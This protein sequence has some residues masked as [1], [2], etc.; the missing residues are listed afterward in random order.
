MRE[1]SSTVRS[2]R[3]LPAARFAPS[4]AIALALASTFAP[5]IRAAESAASVPAS[6]DARV[7]RSVLA[8]IE[9][10]YVD[11]SRVDANRM[12]W[13]AATALD[14]EI[15]EVLLESLPGAPE[16]TL[17]VAGESRS[18]PASDVH[19]I[20]R[21]ADTLRDV[22][23]FIAAHGA[24]SDD[25]SAAEYAAVNGILDSLD[26]HSLL[27]TPAQARQFATQIDNEISGI[28][29]V[30]DFTVNPP[31][32]KSVF[33]GGPAAGA[34]V[35]ACDRLIA[36][37]GVPTDGKTFDQVVDH[38]LG[39]VGTAVWLTF[40]RDKSGLREL[41]LIRQ[42]I[43]LSSVTSRM[44]EGGVGYIEIFQFA[45]RVASE[46]ESAIADLRKA[47][48]RAWVLDLRNNPG[49]L[50][51]EA[52]STASLFLSSGPVVTA[53][54]RGKRETRAVE[55]QPSVPL[56]EGPLA[57]LVSENT[58][59][60]SEVLA[61]ALQNRNRAVVLGRSSF[62]KGTVQVI[63]D[64]TDGS[65]LKLSIAH[66]VTPGG[67]SLQSRGVV[68]DIE[69]VPMPAPKPGRIRLSATQPSRE[70][71]LER[72][73]EAR[74]AVVRPDFSMRYV[75]AAANR[76]D[77]VSIARDLLLELPESAG[78]ATRTIALDHARAF[79]EGRHDATDE[80]IVRVLEDAGVDWSKGNGNGARLVVRCAQRTQEGAGG[81]AAL[82]PAREAAAAEGEGE[83]IPIECDIRNVGTADAFR[84][85]GK[86]PSFGLDLASDEIVVGRVGAGDS[87]RVSIEGFLDKNPAARVNYVPFT[88]SEEGGSAVDSLPVR[89]EV[90]AR[91]GRRIPDGP[92]GPDI[93]IAAAR[94]TAAAVVSVHV[95][96]RSQTEVRD[97]WIRVSHR[98]SK[99]D[100][101]KVS[102]TTRGA[103]PADP[104]ETSADVPLGPGLNEIE[105]CAR[106]GDGKRC[107][108]AF[109]FRT[110]EVPPS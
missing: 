94:E 27:Y 84:V 103:N 105:V 104:F 29:V 71:D 72:A 62:G 57:V 28:G 49:G 66:Y 20:S 65:K 10:S 44:L 91:P 60:A 53:V 6:R 101:K 1:N 75:A 85:S 5:P 86:A 68:P 4:F 45:H 11:P 34:G 92:K 100:H 109:V 7:L 3:P 59:S 50:M 79:I 9:K 54:G 46:V 17:R 36:I 99:L 56:E 2:R 97:A 51:H 18:F 88:F 31:G 107:E 83:R 90:P 80:R 64:Q 13:A 70:A 40:D 96:V 24:P 26:P 41:I 82:L 47:G 35:A 106:G 14:R 61:G 93:Q 77:E 78:A 98:G 76:E 39:P 22:L 58:A 30:L 16:I 33:P 69:L 63:F 73:F 89:I 67:F 110:L 19:S 8:T 37:E 108:T 48:A 102:Y 55:R 21:L 52:V 32:I 38:I 42:K 95:E 43:V 15:P 23:N 74:V 25:G 12:L 87:R 81:A